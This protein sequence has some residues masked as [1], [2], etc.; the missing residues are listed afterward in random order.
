MS[1]Y[2]CTLTPEQISL[3]RDI[4]D[5]A[6]IVIP[7]IITL[8][9]VYFTYR[10]A[11]RQ[12]HYRKLLEFKEKQITSFYSPM[13]GCLKSIRAHSELR[14]DLSK[15]A[16]TAWD[17]ICKNA[18]HPFLEHEERFAP[19]KKLIEYDNI[20]FREEILPTYDKMLKIFTENYWLA[21]ES[22]KAYYSELCRYVEIWHRW[23]D[24]SLPSEVLQEIEH[25]EVRLKPFYKDLDDQLSNLLKIIRNNKKC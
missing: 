8:L 5:L 7:S 1:Q 12:A 19:F 11:N 13:I 15:G 24:G 10:F 25:G 4:V 22:T 6:K 17:N 2:V 21:E 18:P 3:I 23:L 9:A 16:G 20:N 14:S